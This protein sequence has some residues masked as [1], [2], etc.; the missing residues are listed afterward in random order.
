MKQSAGILVYRRSRQ[1]GI[2]VLIGHMGGP[3]WEKKDPGAWSIPK[4][5]V[6]RG[7]E[8][9]AAARR[10]FA[11]ELGLPVPAG[12]LMALGEVTTPRKLIT[13]WALEGDVDP[14]AIKPGTFDMEWPP[15]SGRL[16]SFPEIDRV[17]WFDLAT[18]EGKLVKGQSAFL[19][20]LAS[21]TE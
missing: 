5:E 8:L 20:R 10:E 1:N 4:G 9:E 17:A 21:L 19:D 7:E 11:E 13:V 14:D 6:D 12:P 2:E 3:F 15:G 16:R 18:A